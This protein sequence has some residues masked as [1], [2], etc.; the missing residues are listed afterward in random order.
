MYY[1]VVIVVIAHKY[2]NYVMDKEV[3]GI[4]EDNR[5]EKELVQKKDTDCTRDGNSKEGIFRM[6]FQYESKVEYII[7]IR[8]WIQNNSTCT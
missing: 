6:Y 7:L 5:G 4:M 3:V 2:Y 1:A 8:K